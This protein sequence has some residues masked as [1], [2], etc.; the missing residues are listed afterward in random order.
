MRL[1]IEQ[2]STRYQVRPLTEEDIPAMLSLCRS[3]PAYYRYMNAQPTPESLR[4]SL[5]AL[6]PG[7]T[8][9]DKYF[10]GFFSGGRLAAILDLITGYPNP[11]TAF[12]GWFILDK[13]FQGRG[14]GSAMVGE[15]L[16]FL[17]G[18]DYRAVRLGRV[19]G[20]PESKA[21]WTKN[22]FT[23]TGVE[24]DGGGYTIVIMQRE[25]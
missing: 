10:L 12:T 7:R 5:T 18:Q 25:L 2:L 17:K 4:E 6:P 3:N 1:P 16:S 13:T 22:G 15:L 23:P 21:F 20:N 19:K 8:P 24:T 14:V 11:E 9:A